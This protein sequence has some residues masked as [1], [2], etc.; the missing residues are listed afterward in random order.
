MNDKISSMK[1]C[2]SRFLKRWAP[3]GG[4]SLLLI[5]GLIIIDLAACLTF[6][7]FMVFIFN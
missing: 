7:I 1:E 3:F 2:I 4:Y 5:M 6:L